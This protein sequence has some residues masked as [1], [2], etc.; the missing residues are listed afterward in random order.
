MGAAG[1]P[2]LFILDLSDLNLPTEELFFTEEI[3]QLLL[4]VLKP[5]P[6]GLILL[7]TMHGLNLLLLKEEESI[8]LLKSL[9]TDLLLLLVTSKTFLVKMDAELLKPLLDKPLLMKLDH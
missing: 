6:P 8:M 3:F 4:L 2:D 7:M 9:P 1:S 5:I